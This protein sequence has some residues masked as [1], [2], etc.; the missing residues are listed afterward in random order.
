MQAARGASL[1]SSDAGP[2][3][4]EASARRA[5]RTI[6]VLVAL[7]AYVVDVASKA[8]AV[9][10][11]AKGDIEVLGGI[12]GTQRRSSRCLHVRHSVARGNAME[13]PF[14]MGLPQDSQMP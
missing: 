3:G 1:T 9:E 4:P 13:R 10:R 6:L 12:G 8:W 14:P 2:S 7:T 11:L 5:A